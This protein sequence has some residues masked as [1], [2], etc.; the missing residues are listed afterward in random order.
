MKTTLNLTILFTLAYFLGNAQVKDISITLSPA[1]EYTWWDNHAGL[2]DGVLIGGKLGFGFG[3]YLELR[4][5]YF[6]SVDLTTNFENF[7]LA[8]YNDN[9]FNKQ[10]VTLTRWGGEFKANIGTKKLKPYIALGTGVQSIEVNGNDKLEQ[11]YTS[12]GLG[13]KLNLF[14]R[15]VFLAEVKN[16]TYNF[17]AGAD[18][19]SSTNKS[20]FGVSDADFSRERLSNLAVQGALQFYLGGREPGTMTDLDIAYLEQFRGGLSK[21]QLVIE[22]STS[23]IDFKDNSLFRDTWF[24][25]GY[26][27]IDISQYFAVRAFYFE[28]VESMDFDTDFDNLSMFGMELRANLNDGNGVTPYLS[29]GGGYLNPKD[30]YL[31]EGGATVKGSEFATG[32]LGLNIPLSN[33]ILITGGARAMLTS[34]ESALDISE[35]ND[36]Q[37]HILYNAGIKFSIGKKSKSPNEVYKEKFDMEVEKRLAENE[38]KVQQMTDEYQEKVNALENELELAY[39]EK[40][41]DKVVEIIEE[42]KEIEDTIK[43]VKEL[44]IVVEEKQE[45]PITPISAPAI[46]EPYTVQSIIKMSP[47]EFESL[48][49]SILSITHKDK[50]VETPVVYRDTTKIQ[51]IKMQPN[52]SVNKRI[53]VLEKLL[54]EIN[55]KMDSKTESIAPAPATE[56]DDKMISE[57]ST[58]IQL[59]LDDLNRRMER[60]S[61]RVDN[62]NDKGQTIVVA[63][64][65]NERNTTPDAYITTIDETGKVLSTQKAMN[66]DPTLWYNYSSAM[67]GLNVGGA[68]T[69]NFGVR[70]HYDINNTDLEF[71]PEIYIGLGDKTSFGL[72]GNLI[73]PISIQNDKVAPYVGVGLGLARIDRNLRGNYNVILGTKLPFINENLSVDY[74]MRNTFDYNQLAVTYRLPF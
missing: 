28:A 65:A 3:E 58:Q 4:G 72:S 33:R 46:P 24:V 32:G 14:P 20:D 56:E 8:N 38:L 68:T 11:I 66:V 48:I 62:Q 27:G 21:L 22:P 47:A 64:G 74:T 2:S 67:L 16:T 19:L 51:Q 17:N 37:T 9:L 63:P 54:K 60:I 41:I 52:D 25:G 43:A 23:Y 31:G 57:L 44:E 35:P 13:L 36:I 71:M 73:Y 29:L 70:L 6:Q 7:G 15:A 59:Q 39:K 34:G 5:I 61:D 30:D 45:S 26:A 55:T 18:L 42:K 12:L 50:P 69:V 10:D 40:D 53:D 49:V 1:A